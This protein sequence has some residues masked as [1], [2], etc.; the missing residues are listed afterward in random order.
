MKEDELKA[1]AAEVTK[2]EPLG[3]GLDS[4]EG[5]E[6]RAFIGN[7]SNVYAKQYKAYKGDVGLGIFLAYVY[8]EGIQLGLRLNIV[9]RQL[10]RR[11]KAEEA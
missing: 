10:Q 11:G 5:K 3:D 6:L 1:L 7:M 2:E 4:E 8:H 9:E